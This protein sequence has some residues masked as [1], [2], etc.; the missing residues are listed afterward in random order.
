MTLSYYVQELNN[1]PAGLWSQALDFALPHADRVEFAVS[2]TPARWP[3]TLKPF[4]ASLH[5]TFTSRWRW[6]ACEIGSTTFAWFH[7][8][9]EIVGYLRS[10]PNLGYWLG[11]YPEDPALYRQERAVLW[12][13]SHERLLFLWLTPDEATALNAAGFT[14]TG[15]DNDLPPNQRPTAR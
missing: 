3:R 8:T 13:I 1:A 2:K 6:Q 7:L 10:L 4:G 9:P 11:D 12:T 15:S 14:L 5:E